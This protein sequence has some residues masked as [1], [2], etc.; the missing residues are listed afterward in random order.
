MP[1][2]DVKLRFL[3]SPSLIEAERRR[4]RAPF[5]SLFPDSGP[6]ARVFYPKHIE[7]FDAG[8]QYK[9]RLFMAANR[10]HA[11][12]ASRTG[13]LIIGQTDL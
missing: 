5:F 11:R 3:L 4:R 7:F 9:E 6:L 10:V 12:R 13:A 1:S 8:A 2:D